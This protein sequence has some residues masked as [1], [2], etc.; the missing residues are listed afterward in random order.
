MIQL[1]VIQLTSTPDATTCINVTTNITAGNRSRSIYITCD[2]T[3]NMTTASTVN[4]VCVALNFDITTS[5]QAS[6]VTFNNNCNVRLVKCFLKWLTINDYLV[7]D[8]TDAVSLYSDCFTVY[9]NS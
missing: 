8:D 7:I 6:A 2:I 9:S 1:T 4:I 3:L 5:I